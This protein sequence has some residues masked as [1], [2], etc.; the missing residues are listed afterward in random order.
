M[1]LSIAQVAPLWENVPPLLY[2]GTER[3]IYNLTEGLIKRKHN[4]TLFACGTSKTNAKLCSIY[5]RPLYRD[6]IPW[7]NLMYPLLNITA[8]FDRANEF[9]IIHVHLNTMQDYLALPLAKNIS[10]KVLFT[11]HFKYPNKNTQADRYSVL[12]KYKEL[13][14]SSI[15]NTQRTGENQQHWLGTVYNGIDTTTY[16][17]QAKPKDYFI[18][19]GK[20]KATKGAY[21]AIQ[22]AKQANVKLIL[23]GTIDKLEKK[24]YNY[25][26]EKIEPQIDQKQIIYVGEINDQQKNDYLGHAIALLNPIQWNE[27][28]GL[29]M[30]EAMACGTPVIAFRQGAAAE[31]ILD[32]Q[33][34]YIVDNIGEFIKKIKALNLIKRVNCR[35]HV[36][37]K[38]TKEIMTN[39]Y[40]E[41]YHS[42][43]K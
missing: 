12:N 27:P 22:A 7:T 43:L 5:P 40:L 13:N 31:L 32:G 16:T 24:H 3:V 23:A 19:L 39:S 2:G 36:E 21:E 38:F 33:T 37:Q 14:Y 34:G 30:I 10:Q 18:W 15:S 26:K 9:D 20:F 41:L 8:A 11:I 6:D 29:V 35:Q 1:S 17:Y 25:Y 4:V 42:M 28:F